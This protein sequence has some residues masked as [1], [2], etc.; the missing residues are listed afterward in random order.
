MKLHCRPIVWELI[1]CWLVPG[2]CLQSACGGWSLKFQVVASP[3]ICTKFHGPLSCMHLLWTAFLFCSHSWFPLQLDRL[4]RGFC[5]ASSACTDSLWKHPVVSAKGEPFST[6]Y[7]LLNPF[8]AILHLL[9]SALPMPPCCFNH[10]NNL[11]VPIWQGPI[12]ISTFGKAP[13]V[14]WTQKYQCPANIH[15]QDVSEL[16]SS[17]VLKELLLEDG[18]DS[19]YSSSELLWSTHGF[20]WNWNCFLSCERSTVEAI[21]PKK[22]CKSSFLCISRC[23]GV[24]ACQ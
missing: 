19:R 6:D 23:F 10:S 22:G 18:N 15:S 2:V 21:S 4:R 24:L 9:F 12:R 13:Y 7:F 8:S 14:F 20:P 11:W 17:F 3:V 1:V 16:S 5:A